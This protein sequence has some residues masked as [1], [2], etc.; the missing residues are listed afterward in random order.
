M[1]TNRI[2]AHKKTVKDQVS[3]ARCRQ[4]T[5][6]TTAATGADNYSCPVLRHRLPSG[7]LDAPSLQPAQHDEKVRAFVAF[8]E[9]CL[10]S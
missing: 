9:A 4:S 2:G 8:V 6:R 1:H 10:E 5:W 7:M 3:C